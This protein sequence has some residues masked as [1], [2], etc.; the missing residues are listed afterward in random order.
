[1]SKRV[2]SPAGDA[3]PGVWLVVCD[4]CFSLVPEDDDYCWSC[5]YRTAPSYDCDEE[6]DGDTANA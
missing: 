4:N 5:G 3:E 6:D 1:M 2:S